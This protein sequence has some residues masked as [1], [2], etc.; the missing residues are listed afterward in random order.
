MIEKGIVFEDKIT[1]DEAIKRVVSWSDNYGPKKTA[2]VLID[3]I[4][5]LRQKTNHLRGEL[6]VRDFHSFRD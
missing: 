2:L 4:L 1:V 3:E 6:H 5:K